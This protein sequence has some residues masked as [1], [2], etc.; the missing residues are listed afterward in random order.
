MKCSFIPIVPPSD[1]VV[2]YNIE[3]SLM[4]KV[5]KVD[6]RIGSKDM[7]YTILAEQRKSNTNIAITS[8]H[9][10]FR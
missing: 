9:K 10:G 6:A 3:P 8:P 4:L 2:S 7:I 5:L 1:F